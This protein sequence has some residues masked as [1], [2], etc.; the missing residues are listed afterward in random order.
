MASIVLVTWSEILNTAVDFFLPTPLLHDNF[1]F[2]SYI[3]P[4]FSICYVAILDV[5]TCT[6]EI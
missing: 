6:T 3:H 4:F 5:T 1:F 2:S